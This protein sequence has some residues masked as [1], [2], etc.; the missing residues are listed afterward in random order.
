[1]RV[2]GEFIHHVM[3]NDELIIF[4][5]INDRY[6]LLDKARTSEVISA[7]DDDAEVSDF[8]KNLQLSMIL[9][10]STG[11]QFISIAPET[12]MGIDNYS[13]HL[14]RKFRGKL[15]FSLDWAICMFAIVEAILFLKTRG[16]HASLNRVRKRSFKNKSTR[17]LQTDFEKA[18]NFS[19]IIG[20][21][22]R[23]VPTRFECLEYS[24]TLSRVLMIKKIQFDF[25]I[26]VQ[27]YDFLAHA[28]IEISGHTVGDD[29]KLSECLPI[30]LSL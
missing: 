21:L 12:G 23:F 15:F 16:L 27:R 3:I 17:R 8:V 22:S 2:F 9:D 25:N 1:M 14:S 19:A 7:L 18:H 24:L 13:W 11:R 5:E 20:F 29:P 28:W 30:I 6:L 10:R 26:G 4:D